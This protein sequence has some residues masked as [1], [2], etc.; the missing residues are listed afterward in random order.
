VALGP[1]FEQLQ[2]FDPGPKSNV[3]FRGQERDPLTP[4]AERKLVPYGGDMVEFKM[5][6]TPREIRQDWHHNIGDQY[7]DESDDEFWE[8]KTDESHTRDVHGD[9]LGPPHESLANSIA[10]KGVQKPVHLGWDDNKPYSILQGHHRLASAME[11]APD[12]VIPVTHHW[13]RVRPVED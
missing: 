2:L 5:L 11:Q 1:Q 13:N 10:R 6:M 7:I 12:S 3:P 9:E 4:L 8:R